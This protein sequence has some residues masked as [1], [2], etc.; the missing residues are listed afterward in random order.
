MRF[1]TFIMG[2][3]VVEVGFSMFWIPGILDR[4][5]GSEMLAFTKMWTHGMMV[6]LES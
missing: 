1:S 5:L 3:G 6:L 4:H 2:L